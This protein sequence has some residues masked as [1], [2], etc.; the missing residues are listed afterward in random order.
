MS[1][2]DNCVNYYG[3]SDVTKLLKCW[4]LFTDKKI[5]RLWFWPEN[6]SQYQGANKYARQI[7]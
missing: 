7:L 5:P 6:L 3:I 1:S 4:H 2:I